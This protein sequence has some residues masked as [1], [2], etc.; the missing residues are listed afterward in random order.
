MSELEQ[1][2]QRLDRVEQENKQLREQNEQLEDRVDDLEEGNERLHK[3]NAE[4]RQ[5]VDDLRQ[6]HWHGYGQLRTDVDQLEGR[7]DTQTEGAFNK[8]SS[9]KERLEELDTPTPDT[10]E[11]TV[12][13]HETALEQVAAMPEHMV[14]D[15]LTP[16]QQRARHVALHI[17]D[18]ASKTPKGR[19]LR[20]GDL[21]KVLKARFDCGHSETVSRVRE[22]LDRLG[23]DRV[24]IK[25]PR[26]NA[27]KKAEE[28]KAK[29][30][31]IV[32]DE[33]LAYNLHQIRQNNHDV[34]TG[35][36]A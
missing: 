32:V 35:A 3:E 20:A 31:T 16:N 24:E 30:K 28:K 33:Q 34:V 17:A 8:I 5:R 6:E 22:F 14:D 21:R 7:F 12:Q 19:I 9:L 13:K 18:Y 36:E 27:F 15:Q 29:G 2:K 11:T 1:I 23:G 10:G 4:L 26:T 25:D